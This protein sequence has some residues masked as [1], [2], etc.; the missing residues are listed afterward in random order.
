MGQHGYE[1][2]GGSSIAI[3]YGG[4]VDGHGGEVGQKEDREDPTSAVRNSP[5]RRRPSRFRSTPVFFILARFTGR[6]WKSYEMI[7]GSNNRRIGGML[8]VKNMPMNPLANKIDK[9]REIGS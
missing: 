4:V 8:S 7:T 2:G 6:C 1:V 5:L 3:I 9:L